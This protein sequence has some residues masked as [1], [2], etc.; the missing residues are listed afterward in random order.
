MSFTAGMD[1]ALGAVPEAEASAESFAGTTGA[2]LVSANATVELTRSAT[3]RTRRVLGW[4]IGGKWFLISG[5][6]RI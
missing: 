2:G 5:I 1:S 3:V 4:G 6:S